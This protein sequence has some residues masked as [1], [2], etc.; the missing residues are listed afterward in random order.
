MQKLIGSVRLTIWFRLKK[1]GLKIKVLIPSVDD[2]DDG[3]ENFTP[4][5]IRVVQFIWD[6]SNY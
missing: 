6:L 5:D 1:C 4:E 3:D 2:D